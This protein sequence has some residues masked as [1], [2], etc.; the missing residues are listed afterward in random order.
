[1]RAHGVLKKCGP[2]CFTPDTDLC[3]CTTMACSQVCDTP[4]LESQTFPLHAFARILMHQRR[5]ICVVDTSKPTD[6]THKYTN[7]Q[8]QTHPTADG[9]AYVR[10]SRTQYYSP[11][12]HQL[13]V[14]LQACPFPLPSRG[15]SVGVPPPRRR[16]CLAREAGF[17]HPLLCLGW[18]WQEGRWGRGWDL[19]WGRD[20][21]QGEAVGFLLPPVSLSQQ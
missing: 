3:R 11:P 20:W 10:S 17:L 16:R 13:L 4:L 9:N 14:R 19:V 2:P 6:I 1:M 5:N 21:V 18:L 8:I 12:P 15:C 7:T